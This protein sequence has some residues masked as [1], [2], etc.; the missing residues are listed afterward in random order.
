MKLSIDFGRWTATKA[1][2]A[3]AGALAI[4]GAIG[5][6]LAITPTM[7]APVKWQGGV[8]FNH[9]VIPASGLVYTVPSGRNFIL[10]DLII[11]NNSGMQVGVEVRG[12]TGGTC[13]SFAAT[14][15]AKL[16]IPNGNT[17]YLHLQTGIGYAAGQTVC[18]GGTASSNVTVAGRGFLF[19]PN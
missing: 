9:Y 18:L 14:R 19:T 8:E 12:G 13:G 5:S 4:A 2:L 10:T 15:L 17:S 6:A 1:A 11:A 7:D 16:L 3:V